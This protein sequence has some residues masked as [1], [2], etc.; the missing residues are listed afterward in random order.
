[1]PLNLYMKTA[2]FNSN[3]ELAEYFHKELARRGCEPGDP[4]G[5]EYMYSISISIDGEAINL[6]MGKNDEETSPPL[7]QIWPEQRV[8]LLKKLFGTR[9]KSVEEKAKKVLEEIAR[10]IEGVEGIEWGV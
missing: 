9:D 5:H 4:E 1:M 10:E 7:W 8:S 3:R 6:Y 2:R